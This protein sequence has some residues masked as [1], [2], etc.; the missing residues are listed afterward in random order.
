M[1]GEIQLVW[2]PPQTGMPYARSGKLRV[3]G[4]TSA[5][6][7]RA[8]PD[9]PTIAESGLPGYEATN[10]HALIAPKG[11]PRAIQDRLNGEVRKIVSAPE[12]EKM[13]LANG[14]EPEGG[15]PEALAEHIRKDLMQWRAV[16]VR[17]NIRV[18]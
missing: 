17:A 9:V 4:M 15:T 18:D 10:W 2:S 8:D 5:K 11:L 3:L 14:I 6:R 7:T 12:M 1:A 16:I 13:L